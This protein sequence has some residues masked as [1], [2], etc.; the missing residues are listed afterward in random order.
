M[1]QVNVKCGWCGKYFMTENERNPKIESYG[2]RICPHCGRLVN[3]SKKE[4]TE[5]MV[6]KK[7]VHSPSKTGDIV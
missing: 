5:N 2:T 6:G 4:S 3:A 1:A 7:H